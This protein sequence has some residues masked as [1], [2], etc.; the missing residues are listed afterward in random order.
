M[1]TD[2]T[3]TFPQT[4]GR[5]RDTAR[6]VAVVCGDVGRGVRGLVRHGL[7][8]TGLAVVAVSAYGLYNTDWRHQQQQQL[9]AWLQTQAAEREA[10]QAALTPPA[11]VDPVQ[12]ALAEVVDA[13]A[14]TRVSATL[15]TPLTSEL[16]IPQRRVA[17]WLSRRYRVAP[18][19]M[20][21]VVKEAWHMG[22]TAQLDPTL[23]LA[24][25]SIES[26]FNPYAQS[27][28][29]AQGLMQ[30]MTEIHSDK[31]EGFGGNLAALDPLTNL[32]VG[33]KVLRECINRAGSVERGLRFYVGAANLASDGGYAAK[34]LGEQTHLKAVLAGKPLPPTA[35]FL[36]VSGA[37]PRQTP[38][39]PLPLQA[40]AETAP[41]H[42]HTQRGE[43]TASAAFTTRP[44]PR[45]FR[46]TQLAM[47]AP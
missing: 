36:M 29:G 9:M 10:V 17:D 18:E 27:H 6:A 3:P 8:A 24:V 31:Y 11:P 1:M 2:Q 46:A 23:I 7:A 16:T 22:R 44:E 25:V 20:A 21:S 45:D 32:R 41:A 33:V 35:P 15:P 14:L 42:A 47:A 5:W 13:D 30:V 19:A 28:V 12:Q 4:P 26:R 38:P 40:S 39:P 43:H 37:G 34:V